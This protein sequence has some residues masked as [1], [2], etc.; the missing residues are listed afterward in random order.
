MGRRGKE[1]IQIE[2]ASEAGII[3]TE[4]SP[5]PEG[6][7]ESPPVDT[8]MELEDGEWAQDA[9]TETSEIYVDESQNHT[10]NY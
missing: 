10:K 9:E 8:E 1:K 2:D 5:E 3:R 4:E 7:E 6:K